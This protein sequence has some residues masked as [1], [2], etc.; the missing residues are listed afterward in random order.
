MKELKRVWFIL[1]VTLVLVYVF[2]SGYYE[3]FP[4]VIQLVLSKFLLVTSGVLTAHI[5]RKSILPEVNWDNDYK[6]QL[7]SAVIAFYLIVIY[8]FAMGG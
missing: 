1:A 4:A 2:V 6:W 3:S 8:C 7:T 5:I